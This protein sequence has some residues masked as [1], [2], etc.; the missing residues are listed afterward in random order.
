MAGEDII[1]E[2]LEYLKRAGP[3]NTFRLASV[4]GMERDQLL[5]ILKKLEEKQAI[6]FECGNAVFIKFISEEKPKPAE[7]TKTSFAPKKRVKRKPQ[8]SKA[9]QLLQTENTRLHRKLLALKETLKELEK[10]AHARPKTITKTITRTVV[11]KVPV[12]KTVVKRIPAPRSQKKEKKIKPKKLKKK[13][14]KFKVPKFKFKVPKFKFL[15]SIK[16]LKKPEF[17]K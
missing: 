16:Q 6:R 4:I 14:K 10:K 13:S 17:V 9:L 5:G 11:K 8:K 2:L 12:V 3:T 1:S 7:I 15:K